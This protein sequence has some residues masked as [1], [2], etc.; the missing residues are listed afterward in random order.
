MSWK[1]LGALR[2]VLSV[3]EVVMTADGQGGYHKTWQP[4]DGGT[5][6]YAG[7]YDVSSN[8]G[9]IAGAYQTRMM[10][11]IVCLYRSDIAV[12]MRLSGN[13]RQYMV[14]AVLDVDNRKEY[15]EILTRSQ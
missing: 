3:E 2:H 11:R 10:H 12:G 15:L 13:G 6:I 4:L 5:T 9:M 7:I 8:S 1:D 14:E